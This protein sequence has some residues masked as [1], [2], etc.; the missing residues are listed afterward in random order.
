MFGNVYFQRS[1]SS[2]TEISNV[3]SECSW[4]AVESV[5][6]A[7]GLY[8]SVPL[9]ER[10]HVRVFGGLNHGQASPRHVSLLIAYTAAEP[11][12]PFDFRYA[13]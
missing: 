1:C 12:L 2:V 6:R 8:L 9:G 5:S 3:Y 13:S 7:M 4:Q 10:T 11:V